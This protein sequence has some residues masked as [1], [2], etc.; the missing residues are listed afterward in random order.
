[1][2]ELPEVETIVRQLSPIL[3]GQIIKRLVIH[4]SKIS[5]QGLTWT[6]G[7]QISAVTRRAKQIHIELTPPKLIPAKGSGPG[8]QSTQKPTN[9]TI[10]Y[11]TFHLGM[12]GRLI[13]QMGQTAPEQK[14][15]RAEVIF[16]QGRLLFFD[17]RRFGKLRLCT[18]ADLLCPS[19]QE[20]LS[21]QFTARS[22][23]MLMGR[24]K[25][26]I[27]PWLLRQDRVVGIGNIYASEILFSARIAPSRPVNS[28]SWPETKRL[29]Q[30]IRRILRRAIA[31]RGTTI[32]DF[33]DSTGQRGDGARL[34][35]V[36]G[37]HG[38]NCPRCGRELHRAIQQGRSTFFCPCCQVK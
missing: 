35:K 34:L 33:Q 20:P 31:H 4:D 2:P 8:V 5:K 3:S 23:A 15:L 12:T 36:Y 13:W 10:L 28:L 16:P 32:S 19:G 7:C 22:L 11:L 18:W 38:S 1:M 17:P 14:H 37:R 26:E 25:Q 24:S 30:A 21:E 6:T 27:K 9:G 29:H